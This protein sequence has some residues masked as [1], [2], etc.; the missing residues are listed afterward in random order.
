MW[1]TKK[2]AY[3]DYSKPS[4]EY[5]PEET[6]RDV[7]YL[8]SSDWSERGLRKETLETFG[9]KVKTSEEFGPAKI[10]KVFFP[11]HN[12]SGKLVGYKVKNLTKDKSEKGHFYTL[13]HVG[14]DC[15]LFGQN[16]TRKK[17]KFLFVTEGCVDQLS[18]FQALIDYQ[19]QP[20]QNQKFKDLLPA[21]VSIGCGTVNAVEHM[22]NNAKF[23]GNY[24]ELRLC[25]DNDCLSEIDLKKKNPGMKGKEATEAVGNHFMQNIVKVVDWP[26][27]T[28][29]PSDY[30]QKGKSEELAKTVLFHCNEYN[31][32]KIVSLYDKFKSGELFKPLTQGVYLPGFPRLMDKLL[33]IRPGELTLMMAAS[34]LGKSSVSAEIAYNYAVQERYVGGIFLEE[35]MKKTCNRFIARRL[36]IH[37]NLYKW[38]PGDHCTFEQYIEAEKWVANPDNL[39]FLDHFGVIK[40]ENLID[41]SKILIYKYHRKFIVLDHISLTVGGDGAIDERVELEKA[42]IQLAALCENSEVH[43]I[44]VSHINRAASSTSSKEREIS[45]PKW[46]RTFITDGKGTQALEAL[47]W[48]IILIDGELLPDGT[49]GRIRL[50][51]GKNREADELGFCDI[52]RMNPKTGVFYDAS[53]E[54]WT[55]ETKGYGG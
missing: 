39:L 54:T 48:N 44:V 40:I 21:V 26:E 38:G 28:N 36:K 8:E 13:G 7:K 3:K 55:P 37:P 9:V 4:N 5:I 46:K 35:G 31:T 42:M 47:A 18:T 16:K 50:N 33:G 20:E 2:K 23:V 24:T 30:L 29:D 41:L 11:Y 53:N 19:H 43:I 15:Q 34:G 17:A 32:E 22:A 51:L 12:Q 6:M 25:F 52:S 1:V 14:V 49:R 27:W 45:E 10:E